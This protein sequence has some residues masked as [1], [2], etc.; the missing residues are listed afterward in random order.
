AAALLTLL[1]GFL[2]FFQLEAIVMLATATATASA[3]AAFAARLLRGSA[4]L[5]LAIASAA[6]LLISAAAPAA[7][8]STAA[9]TRAV[10]AGAELRR[11]RRLARRQA[12]LFDDDQP[13]AGVEEIE[14][15]LIEPERR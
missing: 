8:A 13:I 4:T 7:I 14:F 9:P 15:H 5:L 1:G 11:M 10:R 2:G 3:A 12:Q 6:A